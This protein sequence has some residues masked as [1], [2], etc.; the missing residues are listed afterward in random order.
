[1][2]TRSPTLGRNVSMTITIDGKPAGSLSWGRT[3]D[4]YI[5]PG[6]HLLAASATSTDTLWHATLDVQ[7]GQTYA[8]SASY[9]VNQ[10]VLT[11][12]R[13]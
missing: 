6:R 7:A 8:Y 5:T 9:N 10:V 4:R 12:R 1:L 3:V 13:P 11:P 2:I